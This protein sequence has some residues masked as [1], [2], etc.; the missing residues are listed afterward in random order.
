MLAG[1]RPASCQKCWSLEDQGIT[2]D[3]QLKNSAYDFYADKDIQ[4]VEAESCVGQHTPKIVKLYTSN[5]CNSTCVTCG[6]KHSSAWATLENQKTFEIINTKLIDSFDYSNIVILN[7]VG[8]EPLYEKTNFLILEKL[9]SAGN[10]NCYVSITTNG[11]A[12]LNQQQKDI[13]AQFK[14]LNINLSIDGVGPVFEYLRYPLKWDDL[15]ANIDFYR[16]LNIDLSV[17]Y[18]ISNLNVLYYQET[19]DWFGAMQLPYNHNIVTYPK[20]F[21]PGVLPTEVKSQHSELVTFFQ[22]GDESLLNDFYVEVARQ[23]QLKGI[24]INDYLPSM[25]SS[26]AGLVAK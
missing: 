1:K 18:T 11:S 24:S 2:S 4:F 13:L 15:L 23:D 5:L 8:G 16:S 25:V 22:G 12:I 19:I 7:F 3:R 6:P 14:N 17:S 26:V 10:T 20:H 9:I 21:H